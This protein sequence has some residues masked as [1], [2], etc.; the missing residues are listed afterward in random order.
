[1]AKDEGKTYRIENPHSMEG[2]EVLKS[3]SASSEGLSDSEAAARLQ[4]VGANRLAEPEREGLLSRI[5]R[6]FRDPLI[7]ILLA[8]AAV[9]ASLKEWVDTGVILAVVILNGL[10][11]FIQEGKA[12][13]ALAG[14]RK[15]LSPSAD[16]LRDG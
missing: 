7:Y 4:A 1:M 2:E 11:G 14:I 8:A 13:E 5:L 9:T 12:R 6:Q 16:V 10:I 3:L 15:M